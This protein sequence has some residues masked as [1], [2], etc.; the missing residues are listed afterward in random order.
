[1]VEQY[2]EIKTSNPRKYIKT[3]AELHEFI[4]QPCTV[5][6]LNC[7]LNVLVQ[8]EEYEYA[9][10]VRDKIKTLNA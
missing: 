9:C 2:I 6:D 8:F 7:F 5:K 1:M 4:N 3:I 10:V